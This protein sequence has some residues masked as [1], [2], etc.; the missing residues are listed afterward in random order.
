MLYPGGSQ[1]DVNSKGFSWINNY[2]C[3]LLNENAISGQHNP[4]RP[5]AL[6]G[7]AVLCF[8]LSFFLV[9]FAKIHGIKKAPQAYNTS[10]GNTINDNKYVFIH[11]LSRRNN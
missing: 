11:R 3:N 5:I 6:T 8:S 2:W 4:G 1:V 9:C 7:M 10:S